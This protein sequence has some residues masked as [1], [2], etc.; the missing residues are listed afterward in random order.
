MSA[1]QAVTL[2][3]VARLRVALDA[4]A[5]ALAQPQ[6]EALLD[7]ERALQSAL[8]DL[9][10]LD[11]V[12]VEDRQAIREELHRATAALVRCRRLGA[13]L[14]AFVRTS[15]DAQGRGSGYGPR[16]GDGDEA[17]LA[18]RAFTARV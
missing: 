2:A 5:D 10:P 18:G 7:G 12:V 15:L 6:I 3:A 13:S 1:P 14:H 16:A 17:A 4:T 9:P 8:A 11:A